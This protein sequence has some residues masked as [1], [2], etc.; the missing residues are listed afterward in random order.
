MWAREICVCVCIRLT[1]LPRWQAADPPAHGS[2]STEVFVETLVC[3]LV[4]AS[5]GSE[6]GPVEAAQFWIKHDAER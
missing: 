4:Q 5:H 3:L 6:F 2:E 1:A